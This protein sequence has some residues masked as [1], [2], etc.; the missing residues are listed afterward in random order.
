MVRPLTMFH[1]RLA[2]PSIIL[3][4]PL[5]P[6]IRVV[7]LGVLVFHPSGRGCDRNDV[8]NNGKKQKQRQDPSAPWIR[9]PATKHGL[10]SAE[11]GH[12]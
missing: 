8:K 5:C 11:G 12:L 2:Q 3:A 1:Q 6:H 9:N 7:R 4:A 10:I